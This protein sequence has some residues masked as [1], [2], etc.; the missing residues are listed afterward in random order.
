MPSSKS[1]TQGS[2]C[3]GSDSYIMVQY[4]VGPIITLH[5][6]ITAREYM[7]RLGN[8]VP[9]VIQTFLMQFF[10][11]IMSPLTQLKLF[12]DGLKSMKVNFDIFPGQDNHHI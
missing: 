7:D 8:Q 2:F 5:G 4:S 9:P 12:S 1:E 3:D 11:M 10:K 6:R